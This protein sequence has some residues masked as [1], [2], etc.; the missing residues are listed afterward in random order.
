MMSYVDDDAFIPPSAPDPITL[1][2]KEGETYP[3][4][5]VRRGDISTIMWWFMRLD[6]VPRGLDPDAD[7]RQWIETF[8]LE[9]LNVVQ[10]TRDLVL[11]DLDVLRDVTECGIRARHRKQVSPLV[12]AFGAL[13]MAEK[14]HKLRALAD[15]QRDIAAFVGDFFLARVER[16]AEIAANPGYPMD[17]DYGDFRPSTALNREFYRHKVYCDPWYSYKGANDSLADEYGP[18]GPVPC[19]TD[20]FDWC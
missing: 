15:L 9:E 5:N 1:I 10:T 19:A 14:I 17:G 3:N 8:T 11:E 18:G 4:T 20:M 7:K 2:G 16:D 12:E 6:L 13:G